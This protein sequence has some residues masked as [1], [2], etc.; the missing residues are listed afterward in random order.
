MFKLLLILFLSVQICTVKA[1]AQDADSTLNALQQIPTRY[2]N[3]IDSKID[4]Y[5][6]RITTKT[7]KTLTKLSRWENKIKSLL[8][9]TSPE[10]A[11][12]LF[13]P[14]Q[15]TFTS[16]LEQLKQGEAIALTYQAQYNKYT[17]DITTSLKYIA[18][19]KEQ[20]DSGF[21]KKA[22]AAHKKMKALASEEDKNEALQQ[23]IKER[24]K[25]LI[26]HLRP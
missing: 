16:L 22:N 23:F 9:K 20:L 18:Q 15:P 19:Q 1:V 3:T 5:S 13:A 7:T 17:D 2:I 8:E 10:T 26:S 21:I 6:S 11:A 25:Q 14:G 24:K 4:Q 12:Q